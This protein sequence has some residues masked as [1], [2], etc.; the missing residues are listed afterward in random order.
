MTYAMIARIKEEG[1]E[2]PSSTMPFFCRVPDDANSKL[3]IFKN[4]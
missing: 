1:V 3:I 2:N 4:V